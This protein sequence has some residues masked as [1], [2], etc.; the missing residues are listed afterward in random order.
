MDHLCVIC[1]SR[2][3]LQAYLISAGWSH[4][5]AAVHFRGSSHVI[6]WGWNGHGASLLALSHAAPLTP[7]ASSG[8]LGLGDT[9]AHAGG[10]IVIY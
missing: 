1:N 5:L 2:T 3:L 9:E 6:T 4:G 7:S 10:A 8:Q